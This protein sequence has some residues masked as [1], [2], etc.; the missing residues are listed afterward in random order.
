MNYTFVILINKQL[1]SWKNVS[2]V[3]CIDSNNCFI[4]SAQGMPVMWHSQGRRKVWISRFVVPSCF[5]DEI[6]AKAELGKPNEKR[7]NA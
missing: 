5:Y 1:L 2:L 3:F 6:I 7:E 4:F